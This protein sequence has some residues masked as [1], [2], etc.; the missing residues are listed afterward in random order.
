[1]SVQE[2]CVRAVSGEMS[3]AHKLGL[4]LLGIRLHTLLDSLE[5]S[6][7]MASNLIPLS[8]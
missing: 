7:Q 8:E 6:T 2:E 1:M 5:R 3:R 4:I